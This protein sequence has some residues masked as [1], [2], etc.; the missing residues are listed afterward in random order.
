[1]AA[2]RLS[3]STHL[4][5]V[6]DVDLPLRDSVLFV[7]QAFW[8]GGQPR[9]HEGSLEQGKMS[10]EGVE[11]VNGFAFPRVKPSTSQSVSYAEPT[12]AL[13]DSTETR[14]TSA[15]NNLSKPK[16][17]SG[18]KAKK[19]TTANSVAAKKKAATST[20]SVKGKE[21][22]PALE[23]ELDAPVVAVSKVRS[24]YFCAGPS[25]D[26]RRQGTKGKSHLKGKSAPTSSDHAKVSPHCNSAHAGPERTALGEIVQQ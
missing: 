1:M 21:K 23:F 9:E 13:G 3:G 12:I 11:Y 14:P 19:S 2:R 26:S 7:G 8:F 20:K 4:H 6:Q 24:A 5:F 10:N 18:S 15:V 16:K 22:Q 25:V 17:A